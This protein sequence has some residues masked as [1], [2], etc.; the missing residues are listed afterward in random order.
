MEDGGVDSTVIDYQQNQ[1]DQMADS[2]FLKFLTFLIYANLRDPKL[3][4]WFV[5]PQLLSWS[6]RL[7]PF[8]KT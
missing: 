6:F 8:W 2:S 5:S 1:L 4:P 7:F 3:D